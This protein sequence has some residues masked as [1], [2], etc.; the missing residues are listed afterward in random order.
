M[1]Q[2][3]YCT[4]WYH[5]ECIVKIKDKAELNKKWQNIK[6]SKKKYKCTDCKE[7][8][9][10][11]S[12]TST[13]HS[14]RRDP[15]KL[16]QMNIKGMPKHDAPNEHERNTRS[17]PRKSNTYSLRNLRRVN[18]SETPKETKKGTKR[19]RQPQNHDHND[20]DNDD[21]NKTHKKRK[22]NTDLTKQPKKKIKNKTKSQLNNDFKQ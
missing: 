13:A 18:Y 12:T 11:H 19:K 20:N 21:H 5:L 8:D 9:D 14:R 16:L 4:E 3:E 1:I 2:C 7:N 15:N 22:L 10:S 6:K 17:T